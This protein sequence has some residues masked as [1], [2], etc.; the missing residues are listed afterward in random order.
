MMPRLLSKSFTSSVPVPL[1]CMASFL[2]IFA[3]INHF[4]CDG[5]GQR[6]GEPA[7][8]PCRHVRAA[9]RVAG[10]IQILAIGAECVACIHGH[11]VEILMRCSHVVITDRVPCLLANPL[12]TRGDLPDRPL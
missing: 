11:T 9:C 12:A 5:V 7:P 10:V 3:D 6:P 2:V 1:N 4:A 8:T